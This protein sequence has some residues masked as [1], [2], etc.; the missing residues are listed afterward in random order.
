ML[1]RDL[2]T[3]DYFTS[4][5][6]IKKL[7]KGTREETKFSLSVTGKKKIGKGEKHC[8]FKFIASKVVNVNT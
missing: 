2:P 7:R 4:A 5:I 3:T 6:K 1:G 8:N